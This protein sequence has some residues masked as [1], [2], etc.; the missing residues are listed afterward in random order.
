MQ[1]MAPVFNQ[2]E[3]GEGFIRYKKEQPMYL[4][5]GSHESL[6][7]F[8]DKRVSGIRN[9]RMLST[10]FDSGIIV[11]PDTV[12]LESAIKEIDEFTR[13]HKA[14]IVSVKLSTPNESPADPELSYELL[15]RSK[16]LPL[17]Y[18]VK[19]IDELG[20]VDLQVPFENYFKGLK[21]G[22]R[23]YYTRALRRNLFTTEIKSTNIGEKEFGLFVERW[24]NT[25]K[26]RG[27]S[28]KHPDS[29][30]E[31][32][33]TECLRDKAFLVHVED[34]SKEFYADVFVIHDGT[35]AFYYCTAH[36]LGDGILGMFSHFAQIEAVKY[37]MNRGMRSYNLGYTGKKGRGW[38]K[39]DTGVRIFKSNLSNKKVPLV[40]IYKAN[41]AGRV[42][43]AIRNVLISFGL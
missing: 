16:K 31:T 27:Y 39:T 19:V 18:K 23:D 28:F 13:A 25:Y 5:V 37:M 4:K 17:G 7:S 41:M 15:K 40:H 10:L 33:F 1:S 14:N 8:R 22:Y 11:E 38:S 43:S 12:S 20:F 30:T 32:I 21:H 36:N 3:I 35:D 34:E 29:L 42:Y 9:I 24:R 6:V 26:K 2:K